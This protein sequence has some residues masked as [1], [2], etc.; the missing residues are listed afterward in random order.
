MPTELLK[1]RCQARALD[2]RAVLELSGRAPRKRGTDHAIP[3]RLPC[4]ARCRQS[5]RL[6]RPSLPTTT[7]TPAGSSTSRRTIAA[8]SLASVGRS[9]IARSTACTARVRTGS[10]RAVRA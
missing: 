3:A 10:A 5:E 9:S 6:P 4:L 2:P 7:A 1:Q 8:C